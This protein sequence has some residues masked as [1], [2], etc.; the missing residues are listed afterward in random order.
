M[1][2]ALLEY[3]HCINKAAINDGMIINTLPYRNTQGS[4]TGTTTT[5]KHCV[6]QHIGCINLNSIYTSVF[7][8]K[9]SLQPNQNIELN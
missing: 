2:I 3:L 7:G 8:I 1:M 4:V 9:A 5:F 6:L